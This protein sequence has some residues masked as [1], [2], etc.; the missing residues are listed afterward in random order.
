MRN[1]DGGWETVNSDD[2]HRTRVRNRDWEWTT[3]GDSNHHSEHENQPTIIKSALLSTTLVILSFST[4]NPRPELSKPLD[5]H[6]FTHD[7][8][9]SR[10]HSRPRDL[11][12]DLATSLTRD[13]THDATNYPQ[14]RPHNLAILW[15]SQRALTGQMLKNTCNAINSA[16]AFMAW[17]MMSTIHTF[18]YKHSMWKQSCMLPGAFSARNPFPCA[19]QPPSLRTNSQTWI[20]RRPTNRSPIGITVS[21]RLYETMH[22]P[23]TDIWHLA[24]CINPPLPGFALCINPPLS[25]TSFMRFF[26]APPWYCALHSAMGKFFLALIIFVSWS[27]THEESNPLNFQIYW[28]LSPNPPF[29]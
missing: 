18:Q 11:T 1:R 5:S 22:T 20:P 7:L 12:H 4:T 13:F 9:T 16:N 28:T 10:P 3:A 25:Q 14:S 2:K 8:T 26:A 23:D 19:L 21:Y 29:L 6:H 15:L 17:C 27:P 24:L